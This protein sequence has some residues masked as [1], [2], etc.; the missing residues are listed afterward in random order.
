MLNFFA[1][2][3][4]FSVGGLIARAMVVKLWETTLIPA[5]SLSNNVSCILFGPFCVRNFSMKYPQLLKSLHSFFI[6]DDALPKISFLFYED[7]VM[8][9]VFNKLFVSQSIC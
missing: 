5:K 6:K 4:G 9:M 1:F 2:F 3:L 7:T 8:V